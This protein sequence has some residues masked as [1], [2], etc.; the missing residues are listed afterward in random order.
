MLPPASPPEGVASGL[1][2]VFVD[3]SLGRLEV[4]QLLRAGGVDL[5]TLAEHYGMP[6]DETVEDTTWIVD[7]A[8]RGWVAFMK[9]ER[10]RR[11]PAEREALHRSAA[12]CFCM[13]NG[14]LKSAAMAE[15]YL[16]NLPAIVRAC[17]RPGAVSLRRPR[18]P[19]RATADRLSARTS[20]QELSPWFRR[21]RLSFLRECGG[22][23]TVAAG[24]AH[25]APPGP[26]RSWTS[27][28]SM[29]GTCWP[30]PVSIGS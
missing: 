17:A 19:Y 29:T 28:P 26:C 24:A 20:L 1:P 23:G 8:R 15:R 6:A 27:S 18:R 14:N 13:A 11:R 3:R 12:R 2:F 5:V 25:P 21:R 7:S 22:G 16:A 10:I 4:P 30:R 9:D